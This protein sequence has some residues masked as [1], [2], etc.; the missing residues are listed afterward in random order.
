MYN[1]TD[2]LQYMNLFQL[3]QGLYDKVNAI[4]LKKTHNAF[5]LE[6]IKIRELIVPVY[7]YYVT[8]Y[9]NKEI[10]NHLLKYQEKPVSIKNLKNNGNFQINF[11]GI[12]F[13]SATIDNRVNYLYNQYT[14][15]PK[16]HNNNH[17]LTI[18]NTIRELTNNVTNNIRKIIR[19]A[20]SLGKL[21]K[22]KNIRDC[23]EGVYFENGKSFIN[24][25]LNSEEIRK[26]PIAL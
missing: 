24:V 2:N 1:T 17:I 19:N 20:N 4:Y 23:P 26:I 8:L 18:I 22:I 21:E 9:N 15:K 7:N 5:E 16:T 6:F 11:A 13:I 25:K 12:G 10:P 3:I 14:K